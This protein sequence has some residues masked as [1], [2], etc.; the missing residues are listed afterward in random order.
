MTDAVDNV[1]GA[2]AALGREDRLRFF[3]KVRTLMTVGSAP[4]R[5][6]PEPRTGL[7]FTYDDLVRLCAELVPLA[8][9]YPESFPLEG[10]YW[11]AHELAHVLLSRPGDVG[12]PEF[13]LGW[14]RTSEHDSRCTEMAA[15]KVGRWLLEC[16]GR[17][18]LADRMDADTDIST[19]GYDDKGDVDRMIE[20]AGLGHSKDGGATLPR[21]S[22]GLRLMLERKVDGVR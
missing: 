17:T 8:S 13:G 9:R 6:D 7:P 11:P 21:T 4:R 15:N 22:Y 16:V 19:R 12:L 18:D 5:T 2:I 3:V 10:S 1:L 14:P 20:S